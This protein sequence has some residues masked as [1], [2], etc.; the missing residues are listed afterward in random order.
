M[1]R[2]KSDLSEQEAS[3]AVFAIDLRMSNTKMSNYLRKR[4]SILVRKRN[5]GKPILV[6]PETSGKRK[7]STTTG[8]ST[9]RR[10][11]RWFSRGE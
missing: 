11:R 2:R 3:A 5:L 9:T 4:R 1:P 8:I 10:T 7:R 6:S